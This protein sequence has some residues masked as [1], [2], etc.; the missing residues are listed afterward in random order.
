VV[1]L[2]VFEPPEAKKAVTRL[3]LAQTPSGVAVVVVNEKGETLPGGL[4]MTFHCDGTASRSRGIRPGY[5]FIVDSR[6]RIT[7]KFATE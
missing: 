2:V 5:G 7:L 6:G 1:S 4:L 3:K